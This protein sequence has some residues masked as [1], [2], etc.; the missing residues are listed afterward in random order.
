MAD[1]LTFDP[2]S[3][4]EILETIDDFQEE[5]QRP[6]RL[7]FF[8]LDEQLRDYYEKIIPKKLQVSRYE[9][10]RIEKQ[11]QRYRE[12]YTKSIDS[13]YNQ[14]SYF[15]NLTLDWIH[16]IYA[17]YKYSTY[18]FPE[19]WSPLFE[20][21][22]KK[23]PNYYPRLLTALPKPYVSTSNDGLPLEKN[24]ILFDEEG[25]TSIHGLGIFY[26][27]K[28]VIHDDGSME[29]VNI[30]ILN[31]N[32]DLRVKGYFLTK[33]GL[34]VPNPLA[35]HPFLST[36]A[37]SKIITDKPLGEIFPTIQAIMT[38]GV[39]TTTDPYVEGRSYLKVYD[40]KLSDIHWSSW[41]DRFPPVNTVSAKPN[42][43]SVTFPSE[44]EE[45]QPSKNLTE[46]YVEKWFEGYSPRLWLQ[47]QEDSGMLVVKMLLSKAADHGLLPPQQVTENIIATYTDSTAEEC[48][49]FS[50]NFEKFAESGIYRAP[51]YSEVDDAEKKRKPIPIG[52]C[53][54]VDSILHERKH[55]INKDKKPWSETTDQDLLKEHLLS[56][57]IFQ[58]VDTKEKTIGYEKYIQPPE[59]EYRR[60]VLTI[61]EDNDRDPI[62]KADDIQV[63][64]RDHKLENNVY[65]DVAGMFIICSHTLSELRGGMED[66][67]TFYT[68][69]T[70]TE[71]GFQVCKY[72]GEKINTDVFAA[73]DDFD[74]QGN[75]VINYEKLFL[76]KNPEHET[77]YT[78][79]SKLKGFFNLE[80]AGEATLYLIL[81]LLQI[82][83]NELQLIP[84]LQNIREITGA[85]KV[86]INTK[87]IAKED[88]DRVEGIL[89]IAGVITLLQVHDPFLIP[90][91]SFGS[92][93]LRLGGFPRDT[94]DTRQSPILDTII[95]VL[96]NTFEQFPNTFKGP[97]QALFRRIITK[98]KKVKD[99]CLI[100][101]KQAHTKFKPQFETAK[102]R[103]A[104]SQTDAIENST[105]LPIIHLETTEFN[106]SQ[107]I[108]KEEKKTECNVPRP[109]SMLLNRL[110]PNVVQQKVSY[111]QNITVSNQSSYIIPLREDKKL[112]DIPEKDIRRRLKLGFPKGLKLNLIDEFIKNTNDS[113]ALIAMTN[114]I[115]DILSYEAFPVGSI[116]EKRE[117]INLID[118]KL[119]VSLARDAIKGVL[120]ELL[121]DVDQQGNK[122]GLN[123][124]LDKASKSDL[125]MKMILI[126]KDVAQREE[127]ELRA[128]E[129]EVFKQKL[130]SMNDTEREITKML[131]DIG[132]AP[133]II[134][135]EDR[136]LFAKE[137]NLPDPEEEYIDSLR[138]VDEN[139]PEEGYNDTRD[140]T[141]N[142][143][144]PIVNGHQLEVD[145]GDYGDRQVRPYDDYGERPAFDSEEGYGV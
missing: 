139:M 9:L 106:S 50:E 42:V 69:W 121:H 57:K 88:A 39:K 104:E 101:L 34:D 85:L 138:Q 77:I 60:E 116:V 122:A 62:D 74:S 63:L 134:T 43:L 54:P 130:R 48:M 8:T 80:N 118:Y 133:Y 45:Q 90:R 145:Y 65:Y 67:L 25:T 16:P 129:R 92:K 81:S 33:R 141:E 10:S 120:Y 30:P 93:V 113:V 73:V 23:T 47:M 107:R 128:R 144:E 61:L 15:Q 32:D 5:V 108:G 75:A 99:E 13:D 36:N 105:L 102:K 135:N 53:I 21:S 123:S 72:C 1:L 127:M 7:R 132:I 22:A 14:K 117:L 26:K 109:L 87:K 24:S 82:I 143:N 56:L 103:Y 98:P 91:R 11:I 79:L 46:N 131:L 41:K 115:L 142:G 112:I 76:E 12:S 58:Y 137:Y 140:Y 64:L 59:S 44:T 31:T 119:N 110:P 136:E 4:F 37:S 86:R 49:T 28:T 68:T 40:I 18:S 114:R 17:D 51:H 27:T 35:D 111:W 84:I 100:Y 2:V 20:R 55:A 3:E 19:N 83:P 66:T 52:K 29:I 89:G 38:H 96:K 71:D 78:S 126:S 97:T 125:G 124:V 70:T 6:E 95:F 94:D